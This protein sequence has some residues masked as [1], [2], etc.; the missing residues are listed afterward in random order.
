VKPTL[1]MAIIT[2]IPA[3]LCLFAI[4]RRGTGF[5]LRVVVLPTLL[6]L[7]IYFSWAA[8]PLPSLSFIDSALLV[9]G[10]G[11]VLQD[12][13]RWKFTVTDI[14]MAVFLFTAF[15][16]DHLFGRSTDSIFALFEALVT[17]LVPYMAGKLLIE[18]TGERLGVAR[19]YIWVIAFSS[20]FSA[21]EYFIKS[22]P[23]TYFWSHFFPGQWPEW[24]TQLRWGGGR[25]AGPFAQ[26]E[27]AGMM[28]FTAWLLALWMG[29]AN[30]QEKLVN[31]PAPLKNGKF[32]IWMTFLAVLMTQARGPWIGATLAVAIASI[33]L[34]RR[35]VRKAVIVFG[36]ILC[37][38]GP[39]YV[40][41]KSYLAGPRKN[42]GSE[43]ETA[44][45]RAE[46]I[47]N[48][49]PVAAH[50]GDWGYGKDFPVIG[51]Q[52][53]I[54]NEFLYVWLTQGA[55]G[56]YAFSL[57]MAGTFVSLVVRIVRAPNMRERHFA[58]T[59]L[60]IFLGLTFTLTTVY[61]GSQS[62]E[63]MFL[64]MGW[65]QTNHA[66]RRVPALEASTLRVY[67]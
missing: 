17:G 30:F 50:G 52:T 6:F 43:K 8:R 41:S 40:Y 49:I 18:G 1:R 22:N 14:G 64:V 19:S 4:L 12:V 62:Y 20:F 53:S 58:T 34:S 61:L 42:Y 15:Y 9:L 38:G 37:I 29:R 63:L 55:I 46:L 13:K 47:T 32:Y 31:R 56:L 11:M 57:M 7:P 33:G 25:V 66:M 48:Y 26:S 51:G 27:I 67:T 3:V 45:Y 36:C 54:D 16:A 24:H 44:Q 10:A 65:S 2:L 59:L 23:Y 5:A 35:P 21:T 28:V 60:G 39:I